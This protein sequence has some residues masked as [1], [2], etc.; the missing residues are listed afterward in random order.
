MILKE[1]KSFIS[2]SIQ[3]LEQNPN[4][5]KTW[6]RDLY[7]KVF[8]TNEQYIQFIRIHHSM[9]QS[10][11]RSDNIKDIERNISEKETTIVTSSGGSKQTKSIISSGNINSK[12]VVW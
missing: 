6:I 2:K 7:H 3:F 8:P 5:T 12:Y 1:E 11:N 10:L 9:V 4:K